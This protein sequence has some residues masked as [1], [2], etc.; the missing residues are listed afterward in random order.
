MN[1]LINESLIDI[2]H[3]LQE[4]LISVIGLQEQCFCPFELYRIDNEIL[5]EEFETER[6][7][8]IEYLA[9]NN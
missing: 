8:A 6:M 5:Q 4:L 9:N 1:T 2:E 3:R 7:Q